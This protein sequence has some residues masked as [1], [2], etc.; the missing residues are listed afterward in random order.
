MVQ[1]EGKDFKSRAR[2]VPTDLVVDLARGH[3]CIAKVFLVAVRGVQAAAGG[4]SVGW[5][6]HTAQPSGVVVH[7]AAPQ[8]D[9]EES[10]IYFE[11]QF[12]DLVQSEMNSI[13]VNNKFPATPAK[14]QHV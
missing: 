5:V 8:L 9:L 7:S 2:K 14:Q 4:N 6:I 3:S 12:Y 11:R 13:K 10:H 1:L